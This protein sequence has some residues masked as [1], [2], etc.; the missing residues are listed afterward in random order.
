MNALEMTKKK[1]RRKYALFFTL[2]IQDLNK[3]SV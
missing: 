2:S 1:K 3:D